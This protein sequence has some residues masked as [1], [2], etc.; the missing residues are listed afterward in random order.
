MTEFLIKF[1]GFQREADFPG[2]RDETVMPLS[3]VNWVKNILISRLITFSRHLVAQTRRRTLKLLC[4]VGEK[5]LALLSS[6]APA[7]QRKASLECFVHASNA[8]KQLTPSGHFTF[9]TKS[10]S[11]DKKS[12]SAF[13][14]WAHKIFTI[15]NLLFL[16]LLFSLKNSDSRRERRVE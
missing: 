1:K 9:H 4:E 8:I 15:A 12:A 13:Q 5:I 6:K 7:F 16:L 11:L 10:E 2:L 14:G 3:E